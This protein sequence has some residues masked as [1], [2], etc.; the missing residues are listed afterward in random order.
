MTNKVI[1][2]NY[3]RLDIAI[4]DYE[5]CLKELLYKIGRLDINTSGLIL[6][7]IIYLNARP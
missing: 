1:P 7:I 6:F 2:K 4:E 3:S 5:E